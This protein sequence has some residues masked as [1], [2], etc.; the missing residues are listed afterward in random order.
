M[1]HSTRPL[2]LVPVLLAGVAAVVG[3]TCCGPSDLERQ[4]GAYVSV[5]DPLLEQ[6]SERWDRIVNLIKKRQGDA[7]MPRY[8]AYLRET[9]LPYY[10]EFRDAVLTIDPEGARLTE[11]HVELVRFAEA[12]LEFL[13][14]ESNGEAV[15]R[16]AS[17]D[18]SL[19]AIQTL[20]QEG[21][22]LRIAYLKSVG[23]DVPDAKF[24]EMF[25]I[26]DPFTSRYFQ[27][28]QQQLVDP[29]EVQV[30]LR[31]HV[32]PALKELQRR[33]F[34]DSE[35][36]R[37]L[38]LCIAKWVEWHELLAKTCPLLQEVMR[39]KTNSEQAAKDAEAALGEFLKHLEKIRLDR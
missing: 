38:K 5:A 2:A 4:Y 24:G 30:R 33:K 32:I 13:H 26:I 29:S 9:A 22:M 39:T 36:D 28:M 6:E 37:L 19:I 16:R 11:A 27:P 15:Y 3:S 34:G 1:R 7:A 14:L 31:S 35:Q 20:V 23:D 10:T 21:E 8:Y 25:Q 18:G 12:R 17:E